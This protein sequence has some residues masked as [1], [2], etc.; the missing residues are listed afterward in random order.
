MKNSLIKGAFE[1]RDVG[2]EFTVY[3][4]KLIKEAE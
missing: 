1:N 2:R 4:R 3:L